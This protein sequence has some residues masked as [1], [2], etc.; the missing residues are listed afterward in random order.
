MIKVT[1]IKKK[2]LIN[3]AKFVENNTNIKFQRAK[4]LISCKWEKKIKNFGFM[5]KD[6]NTI[7]G[8]WG[9]LYSSRTI[10]NKKIIFGN[11]TNWV[12]QKKYRQHS[13]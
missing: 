8:Y 13:L 7:V 9:C 2:D 10:N 6:N 1:P 12:V 3:L 11:M 4:K 5:L